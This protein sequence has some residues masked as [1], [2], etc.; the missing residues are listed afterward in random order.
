MDN[1]IILK[2][3]VFKVITIFT[4]IFFPFLIINKTLDSDTWFLL[5][6][7]RFIM[8]NGLYTTEPFTIHTN[9]SFIFQQW[10]TDVIFWNIYKVFKETGLILFIYMEIILMN[11][12]A[13]KL[14]KLISQ[15]NNLTSFIGV[16]ILDVISSMYF[17]T[18]PQ[19]ST[20]INIL[21]F[22]FILEMYA[23]NNNYKI[24][25]LLLPISILE[26]NLHCSIW[27]ILLIMTLPYI[28]E[29]KKIN[30]HQL[31][32]TGNNSYKK[33]YLIYIDFL[34]LI[35]SLINPYGIEAPLYLFKSMNSSYSKSITELQSPAFA[36]KCGL[37]IILVFGILI[38][39][40]IYINYS[41]TSFNNKI[42][43]RYLYLLLGTTILLFNSG[44]NV[45]FFAIGSSVYITYCFKEV[46][47]NEFICKLML[48]ICTVISIY[49]AA[50]L[51]YC[52]VNNLFITET[53]N[54]YS[55]IN[56][57]T[58]YML[59]NETNPS[60]VKVYTSFNDGAYLEFYGFKCYLDARMEIMLK[61]INQQND[62]FNEYGKM[63]YY[64]NYKDVF[65]KYDFNYF[66]IEKNIKDYEYIKYDSKYE[67][68]HE[69]NKYALFVKANVSE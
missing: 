60:Q 33:R 16:I 59:N 68:K 27:W 44:R 42:Q 63:R 41:K 38:I 48:I 14:L 5:N 7:G 6:S 35:S 24:L 55:D 8:N 56:D 39:R 18:R 64:G 26:I 49:S 32:I 20:M 58:Q 12:I 25:F 40:R 23:K 52:T 4:L 1:N 13:Y 50:M 10:L 9:F 43:L 54:R 2:S 36:S 51:V 62:I 34:I 69:N 66:L 53:N 3:K 61:S 11:F 30:I 65:D 57:I 37:Y 31:G 21:L 15:N 67:L 19:I 45:T 17:V 47:Y 29:F 28:F 22:L 46:K